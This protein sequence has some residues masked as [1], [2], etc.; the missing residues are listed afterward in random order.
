MVT[1]LITTNIITLILMLVYMSKSRH[2]INS[3][4]AHKDEKK[5]FEY[6]KQQ[7]EKVRQSLL[8]ENSKRFQEIKEIEEMY[9]EASGY[10]RYGEG[11]Y[12]G[13]NYVYF[14]SNQIIIE[15]INID[16]GFEGFENLK[17]FHRQ[18]VNNPFAK[19]EACGDCSKHE[20]PC[21]SINC[22]HPK[23]KIVV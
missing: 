23:N 21:R 15:G 20:S 11:Y 17:D 7:F 2:S 1:F 5:S 8:K 22:K 13:I 10:Y 16:G 9:F 3:I 12:N 6:Q 19:I 18:I 14:R 4:E